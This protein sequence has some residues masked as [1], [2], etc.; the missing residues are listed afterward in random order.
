MPTDEEKVSGHV[1]PMAY[2]S[3]CNHSDHCRVRN[4]QPDV[5][6]GEAGE[7][8]RMLENAQVFGIDFL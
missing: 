6:N 2:C 3:D 5:V 1:L 4:R 7:L 8:H